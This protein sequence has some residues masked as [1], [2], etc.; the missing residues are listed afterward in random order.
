[1]VTEGGGRGEVCA[2][3]RTHIQGLEFQ[4]LL[5]CPVSSGRLSLLN[6]WT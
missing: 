6:P 4:S 3:L 5:T 2:G 1:M